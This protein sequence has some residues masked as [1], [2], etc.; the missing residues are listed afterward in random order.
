MSMTC[1]LLMII[2]HFLLVFSLTLFV[3][4][5]LLADEAARALD[6][7]AKKNY[8]EAVNIWAGLI[9][10]GN[11]VAEY[12]LAMTLRMSAADESQ[13]NGW[14]IAA[15]HEGL[16]DA[17]RYFRPD[18]IKPGAQ[19]HAM[20]IDSPD[21]WIR[22]QNPRNYTLQLASSTNPNLIQKYY[23][24]NN[25]KG[26]AGYYRNYR[27]GKN[28]Y[29]LVYGSYPSMNEAKQAVDTL[30]AELRKWSPWVRRFQDIQR[31]MQPLD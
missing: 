2:K 17:Y 8:Q 4:N 29:A 30:P 11:P 3:Q 23:R 26:D 24:D 12:N 21:D 22:K 27:Q 14:L 15:A 13:V 25:L 19:T 31:I 9:A 28:W 20:I 1:N 5:S 6:A 18:A 10:E 7:M 16:V